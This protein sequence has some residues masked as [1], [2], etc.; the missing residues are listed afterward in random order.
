MA[1]RASATAKREPRGT[2]RRR[3]S[4]DPGR[5]EGSAVPRW[6]GGSGRRPG[7]P[8]G[9]RRPAGRPRV[10]EGEDAVVRVDRVVG[11]GVIL[12]QVEPGVPD[13]PG[14]PP[15]EFAEIDHQVRGVPDDRLVRR[16][17][18]ED[19]DRHRAPVR[20]PEL[21][22]LARETRL[23]RRDVLRRDRS[24]GVPAP[25]VHEQAGIVPARPPDRGVGPVDV[26]LLE[27]RRPGRGRAE[28]QVPALREPA[29]D[30]EATGHRHA[31]VVRGDHDDGVVGNVGE[32]PPDALVDDP[33]VLLDDV[34]ERVPRHERLVAWV[35][36]LR[37]RVVEP[38]DADLVDREDV[39]GAPL[40][41]L[42]GDR[43]PLLG[44]LHDVPVELPALRRAE[45][46]VEPVPAEP[47]FELGRERR[48]VGPVGRPGRGQEVGD[49]QPVQGE[50]GVP[51]GI[52]IVQTRRP[53]SENSSHTE[54][55]GSFDVGPY[56]SV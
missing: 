5:A 23:Q 50:R 22:E 14:R 3:R 38:V 34:L 4:S 42:L 49:R 33:I 53:A 55:T 21:R 12:L 25:D 28:L 1:P 13:R 8:G 52:P 43:P 45:R 47:G 39:P 19:P 20:R 35:E 44:H 31:A 26:A 54:G 30:A 51:G 32:E 15:L 18:V 11:P 41:Q 27:R 2:E 17:R 9:Q 48:R 56:V 6:R 36:V 46:H 10:V 16:E 37:V 7:S 40:V 29:V 24:L